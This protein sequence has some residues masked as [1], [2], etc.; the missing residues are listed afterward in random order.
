MGSCVTK[1]HP[2]GMIVKVN[3]KPGNK[4]PEV[5]NFKNASKSSLELTRKHLKQKKAVIDGRTQNMGLA[6][7]LVGTL[8]EKKKTNSDTKLI[9]TSL[10]RHFIFSS[11]SE[12]QREMIIDEMKLFAIDSNEIIFLQNSKGNAYYI[13]ASGRLEVI[14]NEKRVNVMKEGDSFGELALLHDTPRSATVKTIMNT[15]LWVLDRSSFRNILQELNVQN[16]KENRSFID[17]VPIFQILSESQK[18]LLVNCFTMLK[19]SV[20]QKIVSEGDPG[21]LFFVIKEG[22]VVCTLKGKEIR[23]MGKG[24]YFGDQALLYNSPRTATIVA[25]DE[26]S[27]VALS[28][29]DLQNS[30]GASLEQVIYKNS[31]RIAI[32]NSESLKKLSK[33]QTENV[34]NGM[35][36]CSYTPGTI[37]INRGKAK[38]EEIYVIVKGE[39][40]NSDNNQVKLKVFDVLGDSEVINESPEVYLEDWVAVGEVSVTHI[41]SSGFANSIG[42]DYNKVTANNEAVQL[43]R[44]IQLFKGLSSSQ[45]EALSSA[46]K[47][48]E[49]QDGEFIVEQN[50]PGDS[51][52]II[53]S[54][55]VEII[56][57]NQVIRAITK[58]DYFGERSLLFDNFRSASVVARK[59]VICWILHRQDFLHLLNENIKKQL[60]ERIE[61]Q[62][63]SILLT[64]LAIVKT[65]GSGMFGNVFLTVHKLKR[66]LYALKT[67]DRRKITA[68]EIE[69]NVVLERKILLQLDHVLIMKLVKTFKDSKRLY[70]L[71]EY[72]EGMDLFDVLRKLGLLKECDARFYIACILVIL[73]HLH[74]RGIIY[75]DLKPEN[76]VVDING[77]PKLIDFGTAKFVNGRTYTIVG[78]PHY[79]AP[80]I[81]TSHGYSLAADYWTVGIMLYEFMIG[82]VPFG[83]EE[84][85]PYAI[86]EQVQERKLIFPKWLDNKNRVKEFINQLLSKNPANRLGGSFENLKANVWFTGLNWDKITSKELKAPYVPKTTSNESAIES[87]MSGKK[88]LD[89]VISKI[90]MKEEIPKHKRRNN[91]PKDWDEEF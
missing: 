32:D 39:L 44:R 84:N 40:A 37:V 83:E 26:V 71:L 68:Y 47:T 55:K 79:M 18:E 38:K 91:A 28:Q 41:T 43:L 1:Q 87:A 82:Y 65:L 5:N 12:K 66:K 29:E 24:E 86:Y 48:Q 35:Q 14:V 80:E 10:S 52:F 27:C 16:Y 85:D 69:E 62:D 23:R 89:E 34:I 50:N 73:E 45:I 7:N 3:P 17:S 2:E 4:D 81:V 58:H 61:L 90:E 8:V 31:M 77:Y 42:G 25:V 51:F 36:V 46:I 22:N 88:V 72:I 11:L 53:K 30:L 13:V 59:R 33:T 60:L 64:D 21:D 74:E 75:R 67:V 20:G 78:T 54:G 76:M 63:D 57:D 9:K 70:F 6:D 49:F 56:K 15:A 19:Y